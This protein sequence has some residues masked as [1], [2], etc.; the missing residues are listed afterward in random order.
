MK[1]LQKFMLLAGML[2]MSAVAH[3]TDMKY[4]EWC[5]RSGD[6]LPLSLAEAEFIRH[7]ARGG[8]KS[9]GNWFAVTPADP[10]IPGLLDVCRFWI[11]WQTPPQHRFA[12]G[13][14]DCQ[15]LATS[16]GT[17]ALEGIVFQGFP[18]L[19][20]SVRSG[21][22]PCGENRHPVFRVTFGGDNTYRE[23]LLT[24]PAEIATLEAAGWS[25]QPQPLFCAADSSGTYRWQEPVADEPVY[26][27]VNTW[28][29]RVE[30]VYPG[31]PVSTKVLVGSWEIDPTRGEVCLYPDCRPLDPAELGSQTVQEDRSFE[32]AGLVGACDAWGWCP[33]VSR[34][35]LNPGNGYRE[36]RSCQE[37]NRPEFWLW[38][39]RVPAA[40][41]PTRDSPTAG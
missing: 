36:W 38:G 35:D 26:P 27:T 22:N 19:R 30:I 9:T 13:E 12:A 4:A 34:C 24:T 40:G 14:A 17:Q 3:S 1:F 32:L 37:L 8:W 18:I 23:R 5:S 10:A 16:F 28:E 33:V 29:F 6:C 21:E 11:P 39:R 41:G 7:D 15:L 20:P 31:N 2:V 25:R